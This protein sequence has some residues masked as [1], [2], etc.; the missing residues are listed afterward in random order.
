MSCRQKGQGVMG[1]SSAPPM[2]G[3]LV[4]GGT[5]AF[6][7][8]V[9]GIAVPLAGGTDFDG[10]PRLSGTLLV[11]GV[12]LIGITVAARRRW[13]GWLAVLA[14][15]GPLPLLAYSTLVSES[16]G[17]PEEWG[18]FAEPP[19]EL[20]G[21]MLSPLPVLAFGVRYSMR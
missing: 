15:T 21:L 10:A 7:L 20:L 9:L 16:F 12:W 4:V 13:W 1:N 17:N 3:Y 19:W 6:V 14:L 2:V 8:L 5:L 18:S 11:T